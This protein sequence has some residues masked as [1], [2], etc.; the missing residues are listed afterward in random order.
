MS[1][2]CLFKSSIKSFIIDKITTIDKGKY[3]VGLPSEIDIAGTSCR[4]PII[5]KYR[6]AGFE[7]CYKKLNKTKDAKKY[8]AVEI[9]LLVN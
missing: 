8:F 3:I 9:L 7:N 2:L 1:L 6:L 4:S 5:K